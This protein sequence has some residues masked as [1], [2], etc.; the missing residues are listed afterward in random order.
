[1]TPQETWDKYRD[2]PDNDMHD[3]APFLR[4]MARGNMLEIGVRQ[5]V[6]TSA[7]LLGLDDKSEGSLISIDIDCECN[8]FEHS[9]WIFINGDS[10]TIRLPAPGLD[11]L[12]IDGDHCYETMTSDLNRF[13]SL[14]KPG[15]LILAHDVEPSPLWLPRI[16]YENWYP[17]EEAARAWADFTS[18]RQG[19]HCVFPGKTGMGV[20]VKN[21]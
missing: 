8:L 6:S 19:F 17:V 2:L 4:I 21:G 13:S 5:G 10:R 3:Y 18:S 14:V 9:R 15:G 1:M 20:M 11:V 7:L 16:K 12:L